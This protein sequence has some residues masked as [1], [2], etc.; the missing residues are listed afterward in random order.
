M[1]AIGYGIARLSPGIGMII[2]TGDMIVSSDNFKKEMLPVLEQRMKELDEGSKRYN[3]V[4]DLYL[5]Y[6]KDL[7]GDQSEKFEER[8]TYL[9]AA[10]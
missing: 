2:S 6:K 5:Q 3:S 9:N 4:K 10:E 7:Y 8:K 1:D